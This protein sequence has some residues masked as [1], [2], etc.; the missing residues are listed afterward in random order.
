[1][2]KFTLVIG[3]KNYSSWSL[4]PWLVLKHFDIPFEEIIIPLRQ[5]DSKEKILKHSPSGKVPV[6]KHGNLVIW[7]SLAICEY[8]ADLFPKKNLWPKDSYQRAIARAISSEMHAGFMNLRKSCPMDVR[9]QKLGITL[10]DEVKRDIQRIVEIWENCR[11]HVD[12]AKG[13]FLFGEFS[14]ADCMFA[15]VVFRFNT[16]G[17]EFSA[18]FDGEFP[19]VYAKE[20]FQKM[21][22][23]PVM[24]EWKEAVI[25]EPYVIS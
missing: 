22:S 10:T 3:N 21:L 14:I 4:R 6:L 1:M 7:E 16:Y 11:R 23:L 17:V 5:P 19:C 13:D 18:T 20:Y 24:Q 15:P 9:A 12:L 8:L 2:E 25:K